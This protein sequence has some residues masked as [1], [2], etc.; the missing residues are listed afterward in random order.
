MC[1]LPM[2]QNITMSVPQLL[3][4]GRI[5][6]KLNSLKPMEGIG[7][8]NSQQSQHQN[9]EIISMQESLQKNKME[10][11]K[12]KSNFLKNR[13]PIMKLSKILVA[14]L[15]SKDKV[16]ER[17][18]NNY[19]KEISEK[20]SFH[21]QIGFQDLGP[22]TSL[23][24]SSKILEENLLF[25]TTQSIRTLTKNSLKTCLKL[26][27]SSPQDIM[28]DVV[29]Q[30][31]R[32]V[33]IYPNK[34]QKIL[35]SKC[36]GAHR[37]FYNKAIAQIIENDKMDIKERDKANGFYSL[38]D[39]VVVNNNLLRE[40]DNNLW[41]AEIPFDT[42]QLAV[43]AVVSARAAAFANLKNGNITHFKQRF[44][45][46]KLSTNVFYINKKALI[47]GHL[48][49]TKLKERIGK[50][51]IK[52][53]LL[54][55][56]RDFE[57]IDQSIGDFPIT[58]EKDGR[59]YICVVIEPTDKIL[60]SN[61]K[62]CALD[63]GVRTF[64]TM[65]SENSIGEYGYDTSKTLYN[66]YRREDK[67]KSIIESG[68]FTNAKNAKK[69][70]N[71]SKKK[72]KLKKRCAL[73]RTKL[74]HIVEDLHWRTCDDL[75][76]NFQVILL[77]IFS[78]KQMSNKKQRKIG[79]ITTRLMLGLSHYAFQ[80]K[81]IYKAKQRGR[82]VI[83]CKEHYTSKCCGQC[84]TLNDKLGSKKIFHCNSCNL[85]MDRDIHAARNILIRGLTIY[86]NDVLSGRI[87]SVKK[88]D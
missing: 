71:N 40:E 54:K 45:S 63:P 42:R 87:Q 72:Y 34:H 7:D 41:M 84:G 83:L 16:S 53:S 15:T 88:L 17:Y 24:G 49:K 12:D 75:T 27:Q 43:K 67:L 13:I 26:S 21:P 65:Y 6:M 62:I 58:Q 4:C 80:Q 68:V 51:I 35:F 19:S 66:L 69:R 2:Q 33:R 31:T 57:T 30:I 39:K 5:E 46:K 10:I 77:P 23:D 85:T 60:K 38:R 86:S 70:L 61:N 78:T 3:E 79:K 44:L 32:K 28:A 74:K 50:T 73:L 14:D 81:L 9:L 82:Q 8:I 11:C 18:W 64:Q 36:F 52:H 25:S 59:Y 1:L 48:F 55:S 56:R 47:K 76:K 29:T 22:E 20:L 37:Y